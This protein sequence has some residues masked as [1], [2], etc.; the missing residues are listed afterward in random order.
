MAV[1][2]IATRRWGPG[3][4]AIVRLLVAATEPMTQVAIAAATSRTQPRVSQ[5]L[6]LLVAEDAIRI[7]ER[8]YRGRRGRLIDLYG[9]RS[10]P[11]LVDDE[12]FW[13]SSR[14]LVKQARR[15]HELGRS[16]GTGV[17]FSGD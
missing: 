13:A 14:S 5:V 1:S 8:G 12:S 10:R 11:T 15:I 4:S 7:S 6:K 16:G 17:A 9:A 2:V 3:T